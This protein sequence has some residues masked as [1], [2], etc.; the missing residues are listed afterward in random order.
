LGRELER[1][2]KKVSYENNN[3]RCTSKYGRRAWIDGRKKCKE[4][5]AS[6][7]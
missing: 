5:E 1:C 2:G 7:R 6:I 4:L 3:R